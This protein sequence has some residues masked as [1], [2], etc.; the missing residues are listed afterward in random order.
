[1]IQEDVEVS[2][3]GE[4]IMFMDD[5]PRGS[6]GLSRT[7]SSSVSQPCVPAYSV[8]EHLSVASNSSLESKH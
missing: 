4:A 6:M 7:S 8:S 1:M 2:I 5:S 3:E